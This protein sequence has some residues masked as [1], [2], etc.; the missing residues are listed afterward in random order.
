MPSNSSP[1]LHT[2]RKQQN[3]EISVPDY[4]KFGNTTLDLLA[5]LLNADAEMS[6]EQA[7]VVLSL[8]RAHAEHDEYPTFKERIVLATYINVCKK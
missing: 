1:A 8:I 4:R 3:A 2:L 6:E 5:P 7:D